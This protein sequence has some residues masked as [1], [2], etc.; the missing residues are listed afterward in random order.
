[1]EISGIY[2]MNGFGRKRSQSA[3][4][5]LATLFVTIAVYPFHVPAIYMDNILIWGKCL[6]VVYAGKVKEN[7]RYFLF[8][9]ESI[10]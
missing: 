4:Q 1:M 10:F 6:Q 7:D 8:H 3:M 5:F 2:E 9:I